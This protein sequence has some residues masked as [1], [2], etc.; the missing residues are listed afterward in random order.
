MAI[1]SKSA[2]VPY[3]AEQMYRLVNDMEAYPDFLPWCRA[4]R[5]ISHTEEEMCGEMEV[6][7]AGIRQRFSTCNQLVPNERIEIRLREGP[8]HKLCGTWV[9]NALAEDACKVELTMEF[10]FAGRLIDRAF[11]AVFNHIAATLVDAFCKRAEEIY[12]G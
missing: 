8:F 2:L 9:F 12:S 6:A 3:A 1:V 7:R 11:G 5:V 10:E 4:A